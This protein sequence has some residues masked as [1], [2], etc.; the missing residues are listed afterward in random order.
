MSPARLVFA[1]FLVFQA[2]DGLMTYGAVSI[3]GSAAEGNPLLQTWMALI[4]P[5]PALVGAKLLAS[6]CGTILYV[7][8]GTR[9]LTALTLLYLF[10]A[11]VPWLR[12]LST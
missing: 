8:G 11:V 5:G 7:L 3:W 4:G 2:A 10:A 12:L 9:I 1:I 6:A